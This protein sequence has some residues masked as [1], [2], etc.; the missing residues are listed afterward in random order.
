MT[1]KSKLMLSA[2]LSLALVAAPSMA[3]SDISISEAGG[4]VNWA[5]NKTHGAATLVVSGPDGFHETRHFAAG[6]SVSF[7]MLDAYAADGSYQ[8]SLTI[9]SP[10][11]D[12]LQAQID[13]ARANGD[14]GFTAR[15]KAAGDFYSETYT[16]S[17][18]RSGG[19]IVVPGLTETGGYSDLPTKDNVILDDLIVDGSACVGMDCVNNENF[20]FD[21]LRLKENNLRIKFDD[22]SASGSFPN[23]DWQLVANDTNNGGANRFSIEDVTNGKTPFTVEANA[24]NNTLYVD[25]AG[26]IGVGT[27]APAVDIH[28]KSG[29]SPAL[30]LEQDGSSGFSSHTWDVAGN[31]VNFF[32]RDVTSGSKLPFRIMPGSGN[33]NAIII[34]ADGNVGIGSNDTTPD[35][36]LMVDSSANLVMRLESSGART[37]MELSNPAANSAAGQT[38]RYDVNALGNFTIIDVNSGINA[39][40]IDPSTGNTRIFGTLTATVGGSNLMFPDYVFSED[41]DLM[42][43]DQLAA[44]IEAEGHLPK[45]EKAESVEARGNIDMTK[46]QLQLLEKIEELTLYTLAQQKTIEKLEQ[47]LDELTAE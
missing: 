46:L 12:S 43:L 42:P 47:R 13:E 4:S 15:L 17:F 2:A 14:T 27:N 34:G 22:T 28:A 25:S 45:I 6:E 40:Q 11:S 32:V 30:R 24:P 16:G 8:W 19:V 38:W 39:L 5:P 36:R 20:G 1:K 31:E 41:Y 37:Q 35:A 33:D 23:V 44:Y 10:V 21:T 18:A 26:R 7:S 3:A 29:N 9:T